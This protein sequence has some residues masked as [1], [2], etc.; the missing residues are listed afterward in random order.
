MLHFSLPD[1]VGATGV[2]VLLA[3]AA[4]VTLTPDARTSVCAGSRLMITTI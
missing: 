4:P 2:A 1:K 3:E